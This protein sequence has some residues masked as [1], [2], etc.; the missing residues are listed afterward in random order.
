MI[1]S[2]K[3]IKDSVRMDTCPKNMMAPKKT[4]VSRTAFIP[5]RTVIK[6]AMA[7]RQTSILLISSSITVDKANDGV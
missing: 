5:P 2:G 3:F 4:S 7:N 6:V 1:S